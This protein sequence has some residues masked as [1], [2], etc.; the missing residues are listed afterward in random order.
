MRTGKDLNQSK[1]PALNPSHLVKEAK[2]FFTNETRSAPAK[3]L[4]TN[5]EKDHDHIFYLK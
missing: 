5:K 2:P 4:E 1:Q 3:T